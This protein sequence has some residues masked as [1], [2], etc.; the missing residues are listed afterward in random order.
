MIRAAGILFVAGD[1][2]LFLRRGNGA[3]H[4]NEWAIPGGK[5]E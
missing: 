1:T 5:L 2:A 4:P 3:D